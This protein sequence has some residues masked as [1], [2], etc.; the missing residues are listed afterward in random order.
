[1]SPFAAFRHFSWVLCVS[2][3]PD[4]VRRFCLVA[5]HLCFDGLPSGQ[6][7]PDQLYRTVGLRNADFLWHRAGMGSQRQSA[8]HGT[9]RGSGILYPTIFQQSMNQTIPL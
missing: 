3:L 9:H 7:G 1:M 4:S 8:V 5:I 2:L 6:D